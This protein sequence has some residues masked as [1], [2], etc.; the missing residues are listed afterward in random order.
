MEVCVDSVESAVSAAEGGASRLE[1]CGNLAEGGT[2][3]SLGMLRL[4]KE[5]VAIPVFVMLRPRG[6]D[7]LYSDL[8]FRVM[9][10]DLQLMKNNGA[11]GIVF[12]MLTEDGNIDVER[13]K[14]LLGLAHPLPVTF[15]RAFDMTRDFDAA[16]DIL[17]EVGVERVL[18]SGGDATALE[19]LPVI[20]K[21]VKRSN[22]KIVVVPGGGITERNLSRILVGSGAIEYHCSA[23]SSCT[24]GMR[25]QNTRVSMGASFGP[26]EFG[27]K[28]TDRGRVAAMLS[29]SNALWN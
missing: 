3:P 27:V 25:Y 28:R 29:I 10:E 26:L 5:M 6:G 20:E 12:G 16:L 7:F 4:V 14:V 11:D 22:G 19:G 15:H 2:T 1:L 17:I 18:T 24:S 21:L 13:M 9:R 8:E 23:R